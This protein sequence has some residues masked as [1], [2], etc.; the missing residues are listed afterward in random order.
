VFFEWTA[1]AEITALILVTHMLPIWAFALDGPQIRTEVAMVV[2]TALVMASIVSILVTLLA[3]AAGGL[4]PP[5]RVLPRA[6]AEASTAASML[7]A[8]FAVAAGLAWWAVAALD[9]STLH[10]G[11]FLVPAVLAAAVFILWSERRRRGTLSGISGNLGMLSRRSV[12]LAALAAGGLAWAGGV[13]WRRFALDRPHAAAPGSPRGPNILLITFDALAA[14]D[15]SLY[16]YTLPTTPHLARFAEGGLVFERYYTASNFTT[17][18][19]ATMMTGV[20][21]PRHGIRTIRSRLA[22]SWAPASL[23]AL[24]QEAGYRT[25]AIV[26][27]PAAHPLHLG[28]DQAFDDLPPPPLR[29][30]AVFSDWAYHLTGTDLGR[31]LQQA[32]GDRRTAF[33]TKVLP[34]REVRADYPIDPALDHAR[35]FI[36]GQTGPWFLWLHLMPPHH[37]YAPSGDTEG[38]FL[39]GDAYT[40]LP[41]SDAGLQGVSYGTVYKAELQPEIDKLRLRYDEFIADADQ[42]VGA[43][44]D[45]LSQAGHLKETAIIVSA[46]HGEA[47]DHGVWGHEGRFMWESV[48]HVPLIIRLPD[49]PSGRVTGL[50]GGVDLMPTLLDIAGIKAPTGL[51]G[52]S[53]RPLW[54]GAETA[55]RQRSSVLITSAYGAPP[56]QGIVAILEGDERYIHDIASDTG[57]LYDLAQDPGETVDLSTARPERTAALRDV[58]RRVLAESRA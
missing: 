52:A 18:S 42:R 5:D 9:G 50:A 24:L 10:I 8:A 20:G 31:D 55:G 40:G 2:L 53:L 51:D 1:A 19:V 3:V 26:S 14:G 32:I 38:R 28:L 22:R 47:F 49:G 34:M 16:G 23:P 37:P 44:L 57:A 35:E 36:A 15:T 4:G 29:E 48:I 56:A 11:R 13:R 6:I 46:D 12:L 17:A 41:G 30:G 25:G 27:N 54:S 45:E 39:A 21:V 7:L 58:A 43:F 33:E